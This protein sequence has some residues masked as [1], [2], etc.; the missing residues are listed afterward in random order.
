[1]AFTRAHEIARLLVSVMDIEFVP[2]VVKWTH[3]GQIFN[4]VIEFE[5]ESLFAEAANGTDV[6]MHEGDDN[7]GAKEALVDDAG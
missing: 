7:S 4:L 6:D 3:R 2:D 1:M 5:D